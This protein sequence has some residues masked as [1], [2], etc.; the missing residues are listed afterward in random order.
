M[1]Q[2]KTSSSFLK[3]NF[4]DETWVKVKKSKSRNNQEGQDVENKLK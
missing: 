2:N 3:N 4:V 1:K